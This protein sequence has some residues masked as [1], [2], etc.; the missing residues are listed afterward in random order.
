M[1]ACYEEG[2]ER[3]PALEGKI[4]VQFVIGLDGMVSTAAEIHD[5]PPSRPA[6]GR[7]ADAMKGQVDAPRFPDPKVIECVVTRFKELR[8]PEPQ[9]GIVTVVYPVIFSSEKRERQ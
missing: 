4:A 3:D 9:G 8:F 6:P 2:R 7:L 1:R 5:A